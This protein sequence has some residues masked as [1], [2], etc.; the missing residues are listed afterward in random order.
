MA[1]KKPK[2]PAPK[3]KDEAPAE[4]EGPK[5]C[6]VIAPIGD[7]G[8]TTRR[9]TDGLLQEAIRPVLTE[10]GF[11]V[12]AAHEIAKPGS[13]TRQVIEHVT[14]SEMVV[15]DLTELNPNVM[16]ELGVRHRSNLPAVVIAQKGTRL[17]FDITTERTIFYEG[18]MLGLEDLRRDLRAM[19][20]SEMGS[21]RP[22]NPVIRVVGEVAVE[23][24]LPDRDRWLWE[25]LES[26]EARIGPRPL[27]GA[28][29]IEPPFER[30][31]S[32]GF[33]ADRPPRKALMEIM[34]RLDQ[35]RTGDPSAPLDL[36]IDEAQAE[37][38]AT[39]TNIPGMHPV[40]QWNSVDEARARAEA[41]L[42]KF[43]EN[44]SS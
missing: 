7:E 27:S 15:C 34:G 24:D 35:H 5:R 40:H 30:R 25:K 8:T 1:T 31:A 36:A 32:A 42:D 17:P 16:Y 14:Q 20:E 44:K 33:L 29:S 2:T 26:I 18:D 39:M 43:N 11:H 22:D 23:A 28:S 3:K 37:N 21:E 6:F 38:L 12:V 9:R 10:L 19:A 13:I 41:L 4:T